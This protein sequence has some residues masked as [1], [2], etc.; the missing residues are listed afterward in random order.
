M[1]K[2]AKTKTKTSAKKPKE[3]EPS[4]DRSEE[5]VVEEPKK[6]K[7]V[8]KVKAKRKPSAYNLFVKDLYHTKEIQAVE[9]KKRLKAI[10]E[11]WRKEKN[12]EK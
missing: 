6:V 12:K 4:D 10:A 2:K 1:P 11:R 9:P 5:V 7:K 3:E 8:K